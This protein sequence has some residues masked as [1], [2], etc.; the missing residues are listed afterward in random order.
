MIVAA[1][2]NRVAGRPPLRI[3]FYFFRLDMSSGGAERML[4]RLAQDMSARGHDV[5][6][7]SW[8]RPEA[9][10][11]YPLS[12]A[13]HW[14]RLG[15]AKGGRDKVRRTFELSR[16]LKQIRCQVFVGFV[17][18]A[19]KTVYAACLFANVPI[20]AA[21]RN[22]PEMYD[23][24]F[25]VLVKA[26][27]MGLFILAKRIVVQIEAYRKGYP[28]WLERRIEAIPNPV[29]PAT[30]LAR[31]AVR[32]ESGWTLLCVARLE[33]QKNLEALV[34]AFAML[35]PELIDWRLHIVGEGGLRGALTK[36][37]SDLSLSGRVFLP[38]PVNDVE[39]EYAG[40]NLF[41]LPSRW[42]GFPNALAEAM[43]HGLP[44]VG[45]AGCPGVNAI[46][47][48]GIDGLLAP[49]NGNPFTLADSLRML[50]A[51]S[52]KRAQMGEQ[53]RSLA[54]RFSPECIADRWENLLLQVAKRN[55]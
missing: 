50:M 30:T 52:E 21:E 24:K 49:G 3:A 15:F 28:R 33:E 23:L 44:A 40:A 45:Y 8:D 39:A 19:D 53:A 29:K 20:V 4:L 7:I 54:Q 37:V 10:A 17:M 5:H 48:D 35:A 11:F 51:D 38:G 42:E 43:A 14:H 32:G 12:D 13:I 31:P 9:K 41:C 46:I 27:Y 36:L 26:F 1:G 34:R 22:S 25:G 2:S 6:I 55:V 47:H 16:L 18:S